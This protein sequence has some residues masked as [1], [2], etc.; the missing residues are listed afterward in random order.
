MR[1]DFGI[2]P[3]TVVLRRPARVAARPA[4]PHWAAR[5]AAGAAAGFAYD[6]GDVATLSAA[7]DADMPVADG[8]P[9]AR[10]RDLSG[11]RLDAT[12]PD[13]ARRPVWRTDGARGWLEFDGED[14]EMIVPEA[15]LSQ[16]ATSFVGVVELTG[17]GFYPMILGD[18]SLSAGFTCGFGDSGARVPRL[19]AGGHDPIVLKAGAPVPVGAR[20]AMAYVFD[21]AARALMRDGAEV[22]R[23][24]QAGPWAA[25]ERPLLCYSGS[26]VLRSPMRFFGGVCLDRGLTGAEIAVA[27]ARLGRALPAAGTLTVLGDSSV[28]AYGGQPAVASRLGG[29]RPVRGLAAPGHTIAQQRAAWDAA[30]VAARLDGAVIVQVGLNDL[31]P[32]EPA[33]AAIARLQGLVDAVRADAGGTPMLI[34]QMTPARQRLLNY[35]GAQGEAAHA[36]WLAINA[37]IAGEGPQAIGGVDGRIVGHV[38]ALGDGTGRLAAGYDLGDGI[39]PNAAGRDV[40]AAAWVEALGAL[41]LAV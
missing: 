15:A 2:S 20:A 33:S 29:A 36:K 27:S 21:G 7:V 23:D 4:A 25:G 16:A 40:V 6:P 22:G 24:A 35:Y 30:G 3:G 38:A 31:N 5:M 34:G 28:A 41:D 10:M 11:L 26:N 8:V 39:H 14:D 1:I 12:Q 9:V 13:M 18:R 17:D 37:A 32:G 19:G